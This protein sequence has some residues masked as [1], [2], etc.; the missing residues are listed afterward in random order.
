[1]FDPLS[2]LQQLGVFPEGRPPR[3]LVSLLRTL[4]RLQGL[5]PKRS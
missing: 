2:V 4:T 3:P 5:A 1:M